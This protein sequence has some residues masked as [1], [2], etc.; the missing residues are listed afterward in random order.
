[1]QL[2]YREDNDDRNTFFYLTNTEKSGII[3]VVINADI[4]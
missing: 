4:V 2:L 1:M 3:S